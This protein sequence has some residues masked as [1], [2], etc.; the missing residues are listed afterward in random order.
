MQRAAIPTD[1][2]GQRLQSLRVVTVARVDVAA[3]HE[4]TDGSRASGLQRGGSALDAGAGG[5]GVVRE[6][7]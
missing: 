7:D 3:D 6:K 2:P 1:G 4:R 5:P